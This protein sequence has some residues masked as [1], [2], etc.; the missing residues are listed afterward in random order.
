MDFRNPEKVNGL[1]FPCNPEEPIHIKF[2][3]I[4][5]NCERLDFQRIRRSTKGAAEKASTSRGHTSER[6]HTEGRRLQD[7]NPTLPYL[8]I[9]PVVKLYAMRVVI[10]ELVLRVSVS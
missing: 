2:V 5:T 3:G 7:R 10:R 4:P 9:S 6:N 1:T 8:V